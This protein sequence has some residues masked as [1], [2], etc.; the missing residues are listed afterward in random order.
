MGGNRGYKCMKESKHLIKSQNFNKPGKAD[1]HTNDMH[2]G[3]SGGY[4]YRDYVNREFG[5]KF[6]TNHTVFNPY[7]PDNG[8]QISNFDT[9]HMTED[10]IVNLNSKLHEEFYKTS[11][12]DWSNHHDKTRW[13]VEKNRNKD[14]RR[15]ANM[16]MER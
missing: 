14:R 8:I 12:S 7:Q 6:K 9:S 10:E 16:K 11:P 15:D 2:C 4:K 3:W 1:Q 5:I 13:C